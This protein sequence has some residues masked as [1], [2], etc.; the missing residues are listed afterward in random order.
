M[1]DTPAT[2]QPAPPKSKKGLI[3]LIV[4][5]LVSGGSGFMV[6]K[7]LQTPAAESGKDKPP[8]KR[9]D[10]FISFGDVNVNLA[11]G[12]LNRYL[13]VKIVLVTD[14]KHEKKVN[15]KLEEKKATMRNWL[16]A[17]LSDKSLQEVSGRASINRIRREILDYCSSTLFPE[18]GSHLHDVL[19]EEFMVQ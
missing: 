11:E 1:A 3:V 16:I 5:A 19:F 12:R 2:P 6:P 17:T 15:E 4:V 7:F 13:R 18:G 10:V 8:E 14:S 9:K